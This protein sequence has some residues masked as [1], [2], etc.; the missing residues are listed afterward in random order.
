[1]LNN[2]KTKLINGKWYIETR[3]EEL[4]TALLLD[5]NNNLPV[6]VSF[7]TEE[8]ALNHIKEYKKRVNNL[9]K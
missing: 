6:A 7:D 4:G 2:I 8:K 1:M 3:S 9:N 5:R